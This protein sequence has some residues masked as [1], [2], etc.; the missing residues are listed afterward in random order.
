MSTMEEIDAWYEKEINKRL[1]PGKSED[2]VAHEMM[3]ESFRK[4][5]QD[6]VGLIALNKCRPSDEAEKA[7]KITIEKAELL[8]AFLSVFDPPCPPIDFDELSAKAERNLALLYIIDRTSPIAP[9]SLP[10]AHE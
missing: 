3:H 2:E 9:K 1:I 10:V 4:H 7:L 6:I 8:S 5:Q